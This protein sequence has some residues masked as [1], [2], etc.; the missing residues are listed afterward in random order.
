MT[1]VRLL[2]LLAVLGCA[3]SLDAATIDLISSGGG[4]Y[5]YGITAA[6]RETFNLPSGQ[7]TFSGM[8]GVTGQS[9]GDLL[10]GFLP[11]IPVFYTAFGVTS[12]TACFSSTDEFLANG[13]GGVST[14]GSLIITSTVLTTGLINYSV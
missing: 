12:T 7:A 10:A 9:V 2:A 13:T 5:R 6:D 8:S 14:I 4:T 3:V 1:C 11:V